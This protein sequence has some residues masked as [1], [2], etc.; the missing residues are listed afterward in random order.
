MNP[1]A[2]DSVI[3]VSAVINAQIQKVWDYWTNPEHIIHWNHASDDWHTPRAENDLRVGG[4]FFSR[5]E[6]HDGSM[7]FDFIGKYN[8]V[9]SYKLISYA[10]EDDR[11]VLV[12]F[13]SDGITTTITEV[14]DAEQVN[15]V[16]LQKMG[17]Q[18]ILDNF[19]KYVEAS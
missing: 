15:P 1:K 17:W 5:M 10:L 12:Q 11:K 3:S 18:A 13:E 2:A 7:G 4:K 19:K 16:K 9:E 8:K 14:F 6:A